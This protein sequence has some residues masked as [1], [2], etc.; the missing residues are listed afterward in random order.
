GVVM[1]D[2]IRQIMFDQSIYE[3]TFVKDLLFMPDYTIN[4]DDSMDRVIQL[5]QQSDRYNLPVLEN[6]KYL[7]FISR[8]NVFSQY[9]ILLKKFSSD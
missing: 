4:P 8:A 1:L 9:R 3:V 5:F 7:G 2:N 6:G